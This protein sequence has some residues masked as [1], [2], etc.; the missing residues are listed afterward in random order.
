LSNVKL[1]TSCIGQTCKLS[2]EISDSIFGDFS[3]KA[4]EGFIGHSLLGS[5]VN[6][7]ALSTTSDLKNNYGEVKIN[8]L[9]TIHTTGG[10]KFGSLV[11]DFVKTA[12]GTL[13]NTGTVI[14]CGAMVV[15]DLFSLKYLKP[16]QWKAGGDNLYKIDRFINDSKKIMARRQQKMSDELEERIRKLYKEIN[17]IL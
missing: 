17:F 8:Y 2:G 14:G 4:H 9:D 11:G 5:W 16:F 15:G 10:I 1:S 12:I 6:L 7:G 13:L 3:N